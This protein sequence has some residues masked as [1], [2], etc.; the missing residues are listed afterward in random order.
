MTNNINST[1]S[2][3]RGASPF[4]LPGFGKGQQNLKKTEK[5]DKAAKEPIT[6]ASNS[7]QTQ[8]KS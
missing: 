7:S 5:T 2:S 3:H 6:A 4:R 8:L 1:P